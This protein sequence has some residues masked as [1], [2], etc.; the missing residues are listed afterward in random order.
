MAESLACHKRFRFQGRDLEK[1]KEGSMLVETAQFLYDQIS[2]RILMNLGSL[3]QAVLKTQPQLRPQIYF[4]S[5]LVALS[6]AMEDLV[7][8]E[9]GATLVMACFQQERFHRQETRRY[10]R[11]A[12]HTDQLYV[13][14]APEKHSD[15]NDRSYPYELVPFPLNDELT[16]EWHLIVVS[17]HHSSCVLFRE[18]G[19]NAMTMD[20]ARRFEGVWTFDPQ[21]CAIAARLLLQRIALYRPELSEKIERSLNSFHLKEGMEPRP[22]SIQSIQSNIFGQRLVTYLQASQYKLLKAYKALEAK[23]RKERFANAMVATIRQSLDPANVVAAVVQ[24]LGQVF[25]DCRCL[26]YRCQITDETVEIEYEFV[27]APM[28]SLKGEPW[29]LTENPIISVALSQ[30]RAIAISDISQAPSLKH[31]LALQSQVQRCQITAWLMA[32]IYY[33]GKVLG[34]LELHYGGPAPYEWQKNDVALVEAIATQT[35][36]ALTQAQTFA[37]TETLNSKLQA[38]EQTRSHL[39][40]VVGHELRTPLSTIQVCL[41]SL[42]QEPEMPGEYRQALLE[43][44]LADSERMRTLVQDFLILSRLEGEQLYDQ[45]D[46]VQLQDSV[47]LALNAIQF[48]RSHRILPTVDVELRPDLPLIQVDSEGLGEVLRRLIDNACRFTEA[49]GRVLIEARP[50]NGSLEVIISD[51][52]R[53]IEAGNLQTI[54]D[55]FHQEENFLRRSVGGVGLGLP[56]CRR[57][58]QRLGGQIWAESE[59]LGQGSAFHFTIPA[60]SSTKAAVFS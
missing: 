50:Q 48:S 4:K 36:V 52:G 60:A 6:R 58:V 47:D 10:E 32:P 34:M 3:L 49:D 12:R 46:W 20:N 37:D 42:D 35:G 51:T 11:I 55:P 43:P 1:E 5:A 9:E 44:A 19:E 39:I 2:A 17:Q 29:P 41:E 16:Q 56:I 40:A 13:L 26:L 8:A 15:F 7:L 14:T 25:E 57:I 31:N 53:G 24:E 33:Q 38:L 22:E 23:E 59:G 54:F 21:V 18:H 30:E 45:T 27:P 28:P